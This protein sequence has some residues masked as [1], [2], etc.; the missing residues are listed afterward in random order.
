MIK[1]KA[2]SL[3]YR[4]LLMV[5]GQYNP[6][7]PLPLIPLSDGAGEIV[8]VG[9]EVTSVSV[10]DRVAAIFAQQW[11]SGEPTQDRVRSSTFRRAAGRHAGRVRGL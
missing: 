2:C 5:Q 8:E 7:Q 1:V 4:D 11:L 9:T 6:R 10:G 3:N